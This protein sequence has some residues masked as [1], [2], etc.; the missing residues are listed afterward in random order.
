MSLTNCIGLFGTC[1]NSSWRNKFMEKYNELNIN[2]FNPQVDDWKP[3]LAD[4]EAKHLATDSI[5]LFPVTGETYGLGSL[6][7]IGFSI[8]NCIKLKPNRDTVVLIDSTL[9]PDIEKTNFYSKDL[10]KESIKARKLV[11]AH[12]KELNMEHVY[13]VSTL[14]EMLDKSIELWN[15]NKRRELLGRTGPI[16]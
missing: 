12:L 1:G 15:T 10:E 9:N 8:L 7:E 11:T 14:D 4:I 13:I 3:E 16:W 2:Y 5:I 6:A